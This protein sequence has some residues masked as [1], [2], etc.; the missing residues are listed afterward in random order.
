LS[1]DII[2]STAGLDLVVQTTM[3]NVVV[4]PVGTP[5]SAGVYVGPTAPADHSLL[6]VDTSV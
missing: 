5:G 4:A 6:W 3:L 2:V 1:N